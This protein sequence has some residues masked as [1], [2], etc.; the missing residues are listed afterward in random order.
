MWTS[1]NPE[2]NRLINQYFK[3]SLVA[4]LVTAV[5]YTFSHCGEYSCF[6]RVY[7]LELRSYILCVVWCYCNL[8]NFVRQ[9]TPFLTVKPLQHVCSVDPTCLSTVIFFPLSPSLLQRLLPVHTAS[10]C[11]HCIIIGFRFGMNHDGM[12]NA[13]GPRSQETAKL[14]ADHITMKTNPFIWSACS[15]DY[16]T[17]F[18]EWVSLSDICSTTNNLVMRCWR[19]KN[20]LGCQSSIF[21]GQR[22]TQVTNGIWQ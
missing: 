1:I 3:K 19:Q 21:D 15:R 20:S 16:I 14:M 13:C 22:N 10:K 11:C 2:K 12:G 5:D 4:A 6:S 18:L 17:S 7:N 8:I 9:G